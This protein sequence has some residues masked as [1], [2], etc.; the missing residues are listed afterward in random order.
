MPTLKKLREEK[1]LSQTE[2]AE[3]LGVDQSS[4]CLWERGKTF[5]RNK[6]AVRLA[7]VLGCTL[8]ELYRA[9]VA[10]TTSAS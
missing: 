10:S 9:G 1:G 2:L 6:T 5:P 8:D 7:D 3:L 4:V